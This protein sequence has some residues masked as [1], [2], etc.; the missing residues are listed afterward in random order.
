[1]QETFI[2]VLRNLGSLRE[3]AAVH[4]WV[5]RIAVRESVRQARAHEHVDASVDTAVPDVDLAAALDVRAILAELTPNTVRCWSLRDMD[6]L[7]EADVAEM[8]RVPPGTVSR[9]SV[10]PAPKFARRW[11]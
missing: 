6:G 9:A 3:P 8:L 7:A 10:G 5:R 11:G 2:T 1:M 4:G